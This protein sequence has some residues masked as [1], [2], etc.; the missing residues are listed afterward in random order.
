MIEQRENRINSE[1][2]IQVRQLTI[3]PHWALFPVKGI[4]GLYEAGK[5]RNLLKSVG[6]EPKTSGLDLP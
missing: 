4:R 6:Y 3:K 1:V 2:K 5:G